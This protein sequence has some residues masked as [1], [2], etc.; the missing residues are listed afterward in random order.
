M[1]PVTSAPRRLHEPVGIRS[2][3]LEET[4]VQSAT[5]HSSQRDSCYENG[6]GNEAWMPLHFHGIEVQKRLDFR[7]APFP[8]LLTLVS[9][10]F[11]LS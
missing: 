1:N 9:A 7:K 2:D 3:Q 5:I 4:A 6:L 8:R 11:L 10:D